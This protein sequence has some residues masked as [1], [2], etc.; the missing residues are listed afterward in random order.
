MIQGRAIA[1]GVCLAVA[2]GAGAWS[3]GDRPASVAKLRGLVE[4]TPSSLRNSQY[5]IRLE[6]PQPRAPAR[7]S[8]QADGRGTGTDD[9]S[10]AAKSL[11]PG[12]AQTDSSQAIPVQAATSGEPALLGISFDV[13][14]FGRIAPQPVEGAV[15]TSK[16]LIHR[17]QRVG[18]I[19]LTLGPGSVVSVERGALRTLIA[20][21]D[22]RIAEA[23][24]SIDADTVPFDALRDRG[25]RIRY[26][27]LADAV[28][29]DG[30]N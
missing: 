3:L 5:P 23:I 1:F 26:D 19:R 22:P 7:I 17:G 25:V 30:G 14:S 16:S 24:A 6:L 21:K 18:A 8:S 11:A 29:I 2:A 4:S 15:R 20:D 9:S 28:V 27:A 13:A 12:P 10:I